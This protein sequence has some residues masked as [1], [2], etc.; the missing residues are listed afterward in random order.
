MT[1]TAFALL[2]ETGP[3]KYFPR[4]LLY[5]IDPNQPTPYDHHWRRSI[6]HRL[7]HSSDTHHRDHSQANM[8]RRTTRTAHTTTTRPNWLSRLRARRATTKP[9]TTTSMYSPILRYCPLHHF[10]VFSVV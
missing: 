9:T 3:F 1:A 10:L 8:P 6:R 7:R 2:Q 4:P 5:T